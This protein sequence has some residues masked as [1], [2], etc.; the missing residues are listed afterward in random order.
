ML[1]VFFFRLY[2]LFSLC[3]LQK[4]VFLKTPFKISQIKTSFFPPNTSKLNCLLPPQFRDFRTDA[5]ELR[6]GWREGKA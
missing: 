3:E 6:A 2:N 4:K 1:G 5:L